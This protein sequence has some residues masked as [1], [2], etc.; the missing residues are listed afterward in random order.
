MIVVIGVL[1]ICIFYTFLNAS[2]KETLLNGK[3][4]MTSPPWS[5][6]VWP[7]DATRVVE[8]LGGATLAANHTTEL[9]DDEVDGSEVVVVDGAGI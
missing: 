7:A 5:W 9:D 8:V 4:I 3:T 1:N 2:L 6:E